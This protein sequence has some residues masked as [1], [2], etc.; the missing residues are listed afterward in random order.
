M[1]WFDG[2]EANTR[3]AFDD[4]LSCQ[5]LCEV[6]PMYKS[7][8]F[9]CMHFNQWML[10]QR[11]VLSHSTSITKTSAMGADGDSFITMI[12]RSV[13]SVFSLL[14]V[15]PSLSAPLENTLRKME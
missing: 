4:L 5:W 3:N 7:S 14:E 8:E 6:T 11:R 12:E 13:I 10:P 2:C 9:E 15:P 1:F